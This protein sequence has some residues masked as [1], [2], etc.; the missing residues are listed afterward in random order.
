[1]GGMAPKLTE[2]IK[3]YNVRKQ[4][5]EASTIAPHLAKA[6]QISFGAKLA[7]LGAAGWADWAVLGCPQPRLLGPPA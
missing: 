5:L 6:C 7:G 2:S 4:L 1:M 3:I